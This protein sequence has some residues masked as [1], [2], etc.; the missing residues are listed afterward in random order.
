MFFEETSVW[1]YVYL[2]FV[3]E[4]IKMSFICRRYV[5]N[6]AIAIAWVWTLLC[7]SIYSISTCPDIGHQLRQTARL[8]RLLR[9]IYESFLLSELCCRWL[10][11]ESISCHQTLWGINIWLLEIKVG[12]ESRMVMIGVE[13]LRMS[14]KSFAWKV[15]CFRGGRRRWSEK[16]KKKYK[17][18]YATN[19]L[20]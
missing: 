2:L 20:K 6:N 18:T 15:N 9:S 12:D 3:L 11:C 5:E 4:T 10:L 7:T 1:I 8:W 13:H 19:I 14:V 17:R 16:N